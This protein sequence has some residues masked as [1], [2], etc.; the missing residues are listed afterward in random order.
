LSFNL[1]IQSILQYS[2]NV[3]GSFMPLVYL[4]VG[5]AFAVWLIKKIIDAT[6]GSNN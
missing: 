4:F 5:G 2:Y 6:R 3:F 1:D